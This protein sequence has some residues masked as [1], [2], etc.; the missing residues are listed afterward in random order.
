MKKW[1]LFAALC[2]ISCCLQAQ[3]IAVI[4]MA[5]VFQNYEKTKINELKLQQQA[6]VYR[7]YTIRLKETFDQCKREF[8]TLRDASQNVSLTEAERE[9]KRLAAQEKYMELQAREAEFK[10]YT[11]EKQN[12]MREAYDT[13]RNAILKE[14]NQTIQSKCMIEGI[15]LVLDKS[16]KSFNDIPLIVYSIPSL[17]LTKSVLDELN[18][19]NRVNAKNPTESAKS[20]DTQKTQEG[21][22]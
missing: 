17:D 3:K 8:E 14:I 11:Q 13:M 7:T 16:G 15:A 18:R 9:S 5:H 6:E 22:K 10:Q 20:T 2:L 19:G 12:Q 21:T 1:F 4:D